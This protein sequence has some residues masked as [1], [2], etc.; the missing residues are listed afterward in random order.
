[1]RGYNYPRLMNLMGL[2][3]LHEGLANVLGNVGLKAALQQMPQLKRIRAMDGALVRKHGLAEELETIFGLGSEEFRNERSLRWDEFGGDH[4]INRSQA[5]NN[6]HNVMD[7]AGRVTSQ[8]SGFRHLNE[9]TQMWAAQAAAQKFANL[10]GNPTKANLRRMASL[11]LSKE[12]LDGVLAQIKKHSTMEEGTLFGDTL[13]RLNMD[14][15]DDLDAHSAFKQ[16]LFRWSR[17]II[18]ENDFGSMAPW[19]SH[20]L[21]QMILQ[22]RQFITNAYAK[23][24]MHNVHMRDMQ[25]FSIAMHSL[26]WGAAIYYVQEQLKA[27]GRD[28]RTAQLQKRLDP[29]KVAQAAFEKSGW[30]TY[31]PAM[32]D[33]GMMFAGHQPTFGFRA[34]GQASDLWF[35]NPGTGMLSDLQ[36]FSKAIVVPARE[37][38]SA[39][40]Q[41]IGALARPWWFQNSIPAIVLLNYLS[42][43]HQASTPRAH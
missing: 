10:A 43:G 20:P 32:I 35:G 5:L 27:I 1:V 12:D 13:K 31:V 21:M 34:S 14:K 23:Q 42:Q 6:V 25:T 41:E 26:V 22:F 9:I 8:V 2:N 15:W 24:F 4:R 19:M 33:T 17:R 39:S 3:Q 30:S 11:G 40:K 29:W 37:G 36:N 16:A 7:V 18:Q 28:D 38:R